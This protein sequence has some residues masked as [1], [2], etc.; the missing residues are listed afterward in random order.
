MDG[1][2]HLLK[3]TGASAVVLLQDT[4]SVQ[5]LRHDIPHLNDAC[6]CIDNRE[7]SNETAR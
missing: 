1:W 2:K 5:L 4:E 3:G 6:L 7:N